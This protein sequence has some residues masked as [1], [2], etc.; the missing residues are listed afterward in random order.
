MV[1][2]GSSELT[3]GE[4]TSFIMYCTSLANSTSAISNCYTNIINGT[5]AV[6]KVFDMLDYKPLVDESIG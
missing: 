6:Q 4:L 1:I 2:E 3:A 5:Y